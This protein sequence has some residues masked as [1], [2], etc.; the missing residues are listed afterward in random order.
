MTVQCGS[1]SGISNN[2]AGASWHPLQI[3]GQ[4]S[5]RLSVGRG[6]V[7][8]INDCSQVWAMRPGYG[9]QEPAMD[10]KM[11]SSEDGNGDAQQMG[12][13][14]QQIPGPHTKI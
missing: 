11:A 9:F 1:I 10:G 8:D 2:K 13:Y 7:P 14:L 12:K 3:P 5:N 6:P 4:G